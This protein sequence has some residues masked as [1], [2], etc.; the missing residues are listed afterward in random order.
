MALVPVRSKEPFNGQHI[1]TEVDEAWLERW[2]ADF[3]RLD[4]EELIRYQLAKAGVPADQVDD[5]TEQILATPTVA[6]P[7]ESV[8]DPTADDE[9]LDAVVADEEPAATPDT[10]PAATPADTKRPIAYDPAASS[11]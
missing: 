10:D 1:E 7:L 11:D 8:T 2:P 3:D 9:A 5:V 4:G 6:S